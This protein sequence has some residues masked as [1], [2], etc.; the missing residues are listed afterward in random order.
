MKMPAKII[1]AFCICVFVA[2]NKP[3][4][5]ADSPATDTT[6][7][8]TDTTVIAKDSIVPPGNVYIVGVESYAYNISGIKYWNNGQSFLVTDTLHY[9]V[10]TSISVS[11]GD[12]YVSGYQKILDTASSPGYNMAEYWKNGVAHR[13]VDN[14]KSGARLLRL[15][16]QVMM[17]M[18]LNKSIM[19]VSRITGCIRWST[20]KTGIL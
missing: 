11:G 16:F 5:P 19:T 3:A 6:T 9:Y 12:V 18:Y 20:G 8:N 13:L 4:A 7:V 1:A 10:P 14:C 2:C 15:R 17:F